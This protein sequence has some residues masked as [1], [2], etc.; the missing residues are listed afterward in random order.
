ML[1]ISFCADLE[2]T[3]KPP[4]P[5]LLP[6]AT[7]EEPEEPPGGGGGTQTLRKSGHCLAGQGG[8]LA[9]LLRVPA[10]EGRGHSPL[11]LL[12]GKQLWLAVGVG[13]GKM[14]PCSG[15]EAE[16]PGL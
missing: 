2:E 7:Q 9:V 4:S 13:C 5:T 11:G 14:P 8:H 1:G 6:P 3:G 16:T 10:A 12:A 15:W